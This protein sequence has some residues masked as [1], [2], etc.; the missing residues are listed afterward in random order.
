[1]SLYD[2]YY[3]DGKIIRETINTSIKRYMADYN[4]RDLAFTENMLNQ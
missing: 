4:I 3:K 1:M 2:L